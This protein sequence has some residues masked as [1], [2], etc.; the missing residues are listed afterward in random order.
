MIWSLNH[1][2]TQWLEVQLPYS[3]SLAFVG[4]L[5]YCEPVGV[6]H[7]FTSPLALR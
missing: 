2:I 1:S 6:I 7:V 4:L 3:T 5:V